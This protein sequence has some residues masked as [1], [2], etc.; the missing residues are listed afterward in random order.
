MNRGKRVKVKKIAGI[1]AVSVII[2][3]M[4]E[5][6]GYIMAYTRI[7]KEYTAVFAENR[8]DFK[9]VA[10]IMRMGQR[11]GSIDFDYSGNHTDFNDCVLCN[12]PGLESKMSDD[13]QFYESLKN[14]YE[15]K[16]IKTISVY[17]GEEVVFYFRKTLRG[18]SCS[19][20]SRADNIQR[21]SCRP[22]IGVNWALE[23]EPERHVHDYR[24]RG[25]GFREWI[26]SVLW[27]IL[28]GYVVNN[29]F[30]NQP[31]EVIRI[32]TTIRV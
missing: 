17:G 25:I 16:E 19:I 30:I 18:R 3:V 29:N 10:G 9:Y 24:K 13:Q 26:D 5:I 31:G 4:A 14:I 12:K 32:L 8:D 27:Y 21:C 6:L 7:I 23:L 28:Q 2:I 22:I 15:L 11:Y 1:A 20:I